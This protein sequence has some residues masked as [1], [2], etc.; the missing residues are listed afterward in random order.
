MIT[1]I[2]SSPD[3]HFRS[4]M[5]H[6]MRSRIFVIRG[7]PPADTNNAILP[8]ELGGK[9]ESYAQLAAHWKQVVQDNAGWF[10]EDE[11]YKLIT[12]D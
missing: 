2:T 5:T 1:M 7:K 3:N 10:K 6:K 9:G 12:Q 8:P 4:F 11:K